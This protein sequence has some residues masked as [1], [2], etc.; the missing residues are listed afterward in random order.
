MMYSTDLEGRITAVLLLF[1]PKMSL[2]EAED[3]LK[4]QNLIPVP[5]F[6]FYVRNQEILCVV[7]TFLSMN[8]NN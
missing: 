6:L 4:S 1:I 2:L 5:R 7:L 8:G 3:H